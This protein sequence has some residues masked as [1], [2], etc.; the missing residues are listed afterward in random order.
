MEAANY[1]GTKKT[2]AVPNTTNWQNIQINDINV[3]NGSFQIGFYTDGQAGAWAIFDSVE[4]I[5]DGCNSSSPRMGNLNTKP[6]L[7]NFGEELEIYPNPTKSMVNIK[8]LDIKKNNTY[9]IL[10]AFGRSVDSGNLSETVNITML[11]VGIYL[12]KLKSDNDTVL[13]KIIKN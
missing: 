5:K 9:E 12:M 3:T 11:P 1:G 13:K 4:L 10:D 2:V 7:I 6:I 8:N